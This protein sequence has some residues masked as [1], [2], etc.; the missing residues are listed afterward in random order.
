MS[1][2]QYFDHFDQILVYKL[3]EFSRLSN[4][5]NTTQ[6]MLL[7]DLL[8]YGGKLQSGLLNFIGW[9]ISNNGIVSYSILF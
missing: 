5:A 1:A 6:T 4:N 8:T 7:K 2:L 3:S 9:L